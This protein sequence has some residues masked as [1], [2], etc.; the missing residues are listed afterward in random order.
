M[1]YLLFILLPLGL[2]GQSILRRSVVKDTEYIDPYPK[3][4]RDTLP[5]PI[6]YGYMKDYKGQFSFDL[7]RG[8]LII[9][10]DSETGCFEIWDSTGWSRLNRI[11]AYYNDSLHLYNRKWI[12][13]CNY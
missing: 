4:V 3:W 7:R 9:G 13:T 1:K 2:F 6:V 12:C 10:P 5:K 11:W 8:Y